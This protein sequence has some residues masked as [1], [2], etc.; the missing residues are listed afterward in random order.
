MKTKL[1]PSSDEWLMKEDKLNLGH[2]AHYE[3]I[4]AL[5]NGYAGARASLPTNPELG[6]PG[7]YIAGVFDRFMRGERA[8]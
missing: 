7:T 6:D 4:F 3:S 8:S 2:V 1:R 5:A